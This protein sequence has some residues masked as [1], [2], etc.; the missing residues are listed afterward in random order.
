MKL[1]DVHSESQDLFTYQI[2]EWAFILKIWLFHCYAA[3]HFSIS[4][5]FII[6]IFLCI[7]FNNTY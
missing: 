2:Q 7:I 3:Q 5:D 6:T 1:Q 4:Q